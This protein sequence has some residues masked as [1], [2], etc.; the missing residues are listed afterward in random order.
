MSIHH[1]DARGRTKIILSSWFIRENICFQV[2]LRHFF[3]I[4][5]AFGGW[6]TAVFWRGSNSLWAG[7]A[8]AE[9]TGRLHTK[10]CGEPETLSI[11]SIAKCLRLFEMVFLLSSILLNLCIS[12]ISFCGVL[13]FW[14]LRVHFSLCS[15][16]LCWSQAPWTASV[17]QE[18]KQAFLWNNSSDQF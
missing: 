3:L 15:V 4:Q 6:L 7:P 9:S 11:R 16:S 5:L 18:G 8:R 10:L 17:S 14:L 12:F 2:V 13:W 1:G